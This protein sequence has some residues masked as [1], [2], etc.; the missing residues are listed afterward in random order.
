M[1]TMYDAVTPSNIPASAEVVAGYVEGRYAWRQAD[2]DRFPDA[3]KITI[4]IWSGTAKVLDVE[5][6][7]ATPPMAPGWARSMIAKSIRPVIYCNLSTWPTVMAQ[8]N[9]AGLAGQVDYWIAH[10][11]FVPHVPGGAIACQYADPGPYDLSL[12]I[13]GWPEGSHPLVPQ[14]DPPATNSGAITMAVATHPTVTGRVDVVYVGIDDSRSIWHKFSADAGGTWNPVE[15][16][17]GAGNASVDCAWVTNDVLEVYAVNL[18]GE[19]W[20]KQVKIH[21][22]VFRDWFPI[23]SA[24]E[25]VMV[26]VTQ[27]PRP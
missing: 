16:F 4:A 20:A 7:D 21:G 17:G 26:P 14:P 5:P 27:L 3:A 23:I 12:C 6:G 19:V 8:I 13:D 24:P 10:Y 15:S 11:N 22:G 9:G 1:K 2:W 25:A 18:K